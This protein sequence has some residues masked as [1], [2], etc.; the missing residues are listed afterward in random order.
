MEQLTN[1]M[2]WCELILRGMGRGARVWSV[3]EVVSVGGM[4]QG[5][6]GGGS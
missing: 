4:T 6:E 2:A 5:R 3:K 1:E